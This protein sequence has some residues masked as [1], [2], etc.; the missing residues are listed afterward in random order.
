[1][2]ISDCRADYPDAHAIALQRY[3]SFLFDSIKLAELPEGWKQW[4]TR[5]EQLEA[6]QGS[7]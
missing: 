2:V 6:L 1:M 7:G 5:V 4:L 3:R